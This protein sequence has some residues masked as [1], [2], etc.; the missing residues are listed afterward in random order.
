MGACVYIK[1]AR[2]WVEWLGE[3]LEAW[4][5][6]TAAPAAAAAE[7][8]RKAP[9]DTTT[10]LLNAPHERIF[11]PAARAAVNDDTH[12]LAA[13][14]LL[15]RIRVAEQRVGRG[16]CVLAAALEDGE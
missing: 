9:H 13:Y 2:F 7:A 6:S 1:Q 10:A 14:A 3:Y 11:R 15:K 8:A 4:A 5:A 12:A 16:V